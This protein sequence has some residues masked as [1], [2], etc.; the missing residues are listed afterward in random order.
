MTTLRQ[1]YDGLTALTVSGVTVLTEPPRRL[2]VPDLP[3]MWVQF[4]DSNRGADVS[5]C[6]D[7]S[8]TRS[9]SLYVAVS[10]IGVDTMPVNHDDVID[11]VDTLETALDAATITVF[12]EYDITTTNTVTVNDIPYWCVVANVTGRD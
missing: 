1:F 9:A 2:N 8:K 7:M 12:L 5:T 4:P 10:P 3:A 6:I 11:M